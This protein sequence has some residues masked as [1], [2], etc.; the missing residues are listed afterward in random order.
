MK[1][2]SKVT[3]AVDDFALGSPAQQLL[4]RFLIGYNRDGEFHSPRCQVEV[5]AA[6]QG[7]TLLEA[8]AKDF[9]LK[10][11]S[12]LAQA[13]C[14]VIVGGAERHLP[15]LPRGARCFVYGTIAESGV[16]ATEL[17]TSA[18]E[19][20]IILRAGTAVTGA[21]QLPV[22]QAPSR[23]RKAL[24]VTYG[25]FPLA[26]SEAIEALWSLGKGNQTPRVELLKGEA[27]WRTAYSAEWTDLFA[28]AFSRSNTIQGDP[29]KDGRTQDV[30][31]MR[32]VEKLVAEPR[33]W[34]LEAGGIRTAIFVMNGALEDIN[35]AFEGTDGKV[36]ST[37]LYRPPAPMQDHFSS[38]AA[39]IEDFFRHDAPAKS[40]ASIVSLP[41][42][43]ESMQGA[44]RAG[45]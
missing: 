32:L 40:D 23:I 15:R 36:V 30:A 38:L 24:A 45:G 4:D 43:L 11:G 35:V 33:A 31:G 21:F 5:S 29:E 20:G 2:L 6:L 39:R 1:S 44:F 34:L 25:A 12:D 41:A 17:I 16:A 26:E 42:V 9:G 7:L 18:E 19:G 10:L 14:A 8:R 37:Q 13:K 28:S 27:V 3:F 22:I